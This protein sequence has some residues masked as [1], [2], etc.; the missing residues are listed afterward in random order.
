MCGS[1]LGRERT[2]RVYTVLKISSSGSGPRVRRWF[3]VGHFGGFMEGIYVRVKFFVRGPPPRG[4]AR[5]G[6]ALLASSDRWGGARPLAGATA[7]PSREFPVIANTRAR[8]FRYRWWLLI[9][10]G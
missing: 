5:G 9:T 4:R 6:D 3:F 7:S 8:R 10:L 2:D 1:L